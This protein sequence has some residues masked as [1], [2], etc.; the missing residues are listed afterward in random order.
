LHFGEA[1]EAE[2]K[3]LENALDAHTKDNRDKRKGL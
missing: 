2:I 3:T 1:L